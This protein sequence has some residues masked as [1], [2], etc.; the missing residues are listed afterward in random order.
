MP[1]VREAAAVGVPDARLGEAIA[2]FVAPRAGAALSEHAIRA[3]CAGH[4]EDFMVPRYIEIR[5]ELPKG[6]TGKI[7][8]QELRACAASRVV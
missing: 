8:K 6:G 3:Y 2:V 5:P 1:G 7:D 4:L